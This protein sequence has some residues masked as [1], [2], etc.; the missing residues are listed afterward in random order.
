MSC[1]SKCFIDMFLKHTLCASFQ[2]VSTIH[3]FAF[4]FCNMITLTNIIETMFKILCVTVMII[5]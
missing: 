1:F 3:S 4:L 2:I 5:K